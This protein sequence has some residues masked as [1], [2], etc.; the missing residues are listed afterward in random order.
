MSL[1]TRG[2]GIS[3]GRRSRQATVSK[4]VVFW[5]VSGQLQRHVL[6]TRFIHDCGYHRRDEELAAA[7]LAILGT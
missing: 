6:M 5:L 4:S 1:E 2:K 7:K 3:R